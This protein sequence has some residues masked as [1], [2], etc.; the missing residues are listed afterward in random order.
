LAE[1]LQRYRT[2]MAACGVPP[3]VQRDVL[4]GTLARTL[5]VSGGGR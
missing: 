3:D 5:A 2:A 4:G 1:V